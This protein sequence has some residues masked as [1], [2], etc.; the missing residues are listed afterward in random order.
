[1]AGP[2]ARREEFGDGAVGEAAD[3]RGPFAPA[4]LEVEELGGAARREALRDQ[5]LVAFP[6]QTGE[7]D[8]ASLS[9]VDGALAG[10]KI[11]TSR[12]PGDCTG[13]GEVLVLGARRNVGESFPCRR[14]RNTIG[15]PR[16]PAQPSMTPR[17][18]PK[19]NAAT[20]A[21]VGRA[22]T[23]SH[24]AIRAWVRAR[25][26]ASSGAFVA[27]L[28][29]APRVTGMS[30]DLEEARRFVQPDDGPGACRDRCRGRHALSLRSSAATA[31]ASARAASSSCRTATAGGFARCG[32]Q[33]NSVAKLLGGP[34]RRI[35]ICLRVEAW[36][37]AI[38]GLTRRAHQRGHWNSRLV[39]PRLSRL[40]ATPRGRRT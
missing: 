6:F 11:G 2:S 25:I 27:L 12:P 33:P 4:V 32:L 26:P 16:A 19:A 28:P 5:T 13:A 35:E 37:Y 1:M 39:G 21:S 22:P 9:A 3:R 14:F 15:R 17:A 8:Q 23:N 24:K 29:F 34:P 10:E 38:F 36:T 7:G 40:F 30:C 31:S 20:L 18:R